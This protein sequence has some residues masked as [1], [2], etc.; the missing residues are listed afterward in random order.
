MARF[1]AVNQGESV[2][3]S[4]LNDELNLSKGNRSN[5]LKNLHVGLGW[6]VHSTIQAD[7]DAFIVQL[8]DEDKVIDVIYFN[9]LKSNDKAIVH[10]GDNL[11][12]EGEGDDE[13]ININLTKLDPAT[14]RIV[15]A[16]NIYQCR[17]TFDDVENAFVRILNKDNHELL[18]QYDL[19]NEFGSNYSMIAGEIIKN[20]DGTWDFKAVGK[21]TKDK[22][23]N[24]VVARVSK[25]KR[26]KEVVKRG[27][28]FGFLG[29]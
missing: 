17:I 22:D 9:H 16:V 15:V 13:V 14:K 26:T 6:D 27:G 4:K 23:I 24:Q 10:T 25:G 3:L 5:T 29:F 2:N 19:S 28:L 21:A 1:T 11:T 18:I 7:L 12:G 20:D 8:D